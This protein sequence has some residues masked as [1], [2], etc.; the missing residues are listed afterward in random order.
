[1]T[2]R[3]EQESVD[4]PVRRAAAEAHPNIALVKYWGKRDRTRNLP[5]VPSL[6]VTLGAL[7]TRTRIGLEPGLEADRATLNGEAVSPPQLARVRS[8]LDCMRA[9]TDCRW[10]AQ[11]ESHNNFP[12]AAGLASSASG[13]AA[14]VVAAAHAFGLELEAERLS[15]LARR[16]SGSAARSIF[17]GFVEMA[18][19]VRSD[20]ADAVAR[21]LL[22]PSD[23]PLEVVVATT[24]TAPKT[25]TST[26]GMEHS[27]TT[28]VFYDAWVARADADLLAAREALAARDFDSLAAVS[29]ASCLKMHAVAL[30]AR[31]GLLYWNGATV[32][33]VRR[34]RQLRE[35][36]V[37]VFF[38]VDAGPQVKAVCLPGYGERVAME[39]GAIPGVGDTLVSGLGDGARPL[40]WEPFP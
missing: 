19:G 11:I 36:G 33:A 23:W 25:V 5:A 10:H 20:G 18:C 38:S 31:P 30:A 6:S 28:S 21:P 26:D 2:R 9:L 16:G 7:W 39:L 24:D 4:V 3:A 37:P 32:D 14:L 35:Q 29:E 22:A 1:M 27:A 12:T 15:E 13:F 34:I 17:G 8:T 40:P